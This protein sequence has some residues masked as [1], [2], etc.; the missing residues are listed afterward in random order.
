[1][2]ALIQFTVPRKLSSRPER[3]VSEGLVLGG[4]EKRSGGTSCF[5]RAHPTLAGKNKRFWGP[6]S[7]RKGRVHGGEK[8]QTERL[9]RLILP[10][11]TKQETTRNKERRTRLVSMAAQPKMMSS[12][13]MVSYSIN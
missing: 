3:L 13:K 11:H 4:N 10:P 5:V 2:T 7:L 1:M 6:R 12:T 8:T 9:R